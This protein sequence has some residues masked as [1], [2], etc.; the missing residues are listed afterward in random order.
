MLGVQCP[1]AVCIRVKKLQFVVVNLGKLEFKLLE[2]LDFL[3]LHRGPALQNQLTSFHFRTTLVERRHAST[4]APAALQPSSAHCFAI[5]LEDFSKF[6]LLLG[7]TEANGLDFLLI[8]VFSHGLRRFRVN[9]KFK[10][11][12]PSGTLRLTRTRIRGQI[13]SSVQP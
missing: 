7:Q 10:C 4:S 3:A 12:W 11:Q 8:Q 1:T 2:L 13:S 6:K 9:V 5:E